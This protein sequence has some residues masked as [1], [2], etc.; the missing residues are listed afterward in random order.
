MTYVRFIVNSLLAP[1]RAFSD[2]V[3]RQGLLVL[4][5]LLVLQA[6]A[7][8][9]CL[10]IPTPSTRAT[11]VAAAVEAGSTDPA[12]DAAERRMARATQRIAFKLEADL[13]RV[14]VTLAASWLAGLL[15]IR[16]KLSIA[17][18]IAAMTVAEAVSAV[19]F[20]IDLGLAFSSFELLT[21]D[22]TIGGVLR[23]EWPFLAPLGAI[24][25]V[26]LWWAIS[27]GSALAAAYNRPL[28]VVVP[29]VVGVT[30]SWLVVL[31]ARHIL[32]L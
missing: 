20:F 14:S 18:I 10:L 17:S 30:V 12:H 27:G 31:N 13:T 19:I 11:Q 6:G 16:K 1:T 29:Y 32:H 4:A 21:R 9:A 24:P 26:T 2:L 25:L 15:I 3:P 5:G 28:Q 7:Q 8:A 23:T 22:L